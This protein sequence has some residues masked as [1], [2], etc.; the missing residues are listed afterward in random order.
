[1][2]ASISSNDSTLY[3]FG[4]P[5]TFARADIGG[6]TRDPRV[7]ERRGGDTPLTALSCSTRTWMTGA[8]GPFN[9]PLF[10]CDDLVERELV[11]RAIATCRLGLFVGDT[12]F[13]Y[14]PSLTLSH[15]LWSDP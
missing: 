13:T 11:P 8:S 5:G 3:R 15:R 7:T 14:Q 12:D 10:H 4:C 6:R 2:S 9:D 1:L